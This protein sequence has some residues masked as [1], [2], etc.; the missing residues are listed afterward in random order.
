MW[1]FHR[2][3]P[4][5][6]PIHTFLGPGNGSARICTVRG[7]RDGYELGDERKPGKASLN[8]GPEGSVHLGQQG[9]QGR[10]HSCPYI[11]C[12]VNVPAYFHAT[13]NRPLSTCFNWRHRHYETRALPWKCVMFWGTQSW[14]ELTLVAYGS[15]CAPGMGLVCKTA[16]G[17][18]LIWD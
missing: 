9:E 11:C 1:P 5:G 2:P 13:T 3:R 17:L 16:D 18:T 4:E 7:G 10:I 6:V 15:G 14:K 8:P 12:I